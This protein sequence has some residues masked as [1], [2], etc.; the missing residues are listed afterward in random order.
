MSSVPMGSVGDPSSYWGRSNWELEVGM[1]QSPFPH[2]ADPGWG[3][4]GWNSLLL[5]NSAKWVRSELI[6]FQTQTVVN[7]TVAVLLTEH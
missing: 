5:P 1:A 3:V 2:P 4:L 7:E 6:C